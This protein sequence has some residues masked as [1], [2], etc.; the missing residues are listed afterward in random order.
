MRPYMEAVLDHGIITSLTPTFG[1]SED[2]E[3]YANGTASGFSA[4][5]GWNGAAAI[6]GT[7]AGSITTGTR[8]FPTGD[9]KYL[10]LPHNAGYARKFSWGSDWT[11]IRIGLLMA[12]PGGTSI[13]GTTL[14]FGVGNGTAN[15]YDASPN[16]IGFST[17]VTGTPTQTWQFQSTPSY[18]KMA[19][20]RGSV[21]NYIGGFQTS[22]QDGGGSGLIDIPS[23]EDPPRKGAIF[24]EINK[25]ASATNYGL[26]LYDVESGVMAGTGFDTGLHRFFANLDDRDKPETLIYTA[27]SGYSIAAS[28]AAG[29]FDSFS[30]SFRSSAG[31]RVIQIYALGAVRLY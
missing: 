10:E 13:T 11:K 21:Q 25:A 27:S 20:V 7:G 30:F 31:G 6:L 2:F 22:Y 16:W 9:K 17:S 23:D 4:G 15:E 28:E 29:V 3:K 14:W 24:L 26:T 18:F 19:S 5:Y 12:V 8:S 1:A